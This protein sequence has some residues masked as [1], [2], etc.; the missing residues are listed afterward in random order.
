MTVN[1]RIFH[2]Q[3]SIFIILLLNLTLAGGAL[4][5]AAVDAP[6]AATAVVPLWLDGAAESQGLHE[7]EQVKDYGSPDHP[8]RSVRN[9]TEPDLEFFRAPHPDGCGVIILPG[10]GYYAESLE[11]WKA[12][13]LRAGSIRLT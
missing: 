10:G 11:H 5:T 13:T 4:A 2:M 7:A 1:K 12:T 8:N 9:I 6:P 3:K